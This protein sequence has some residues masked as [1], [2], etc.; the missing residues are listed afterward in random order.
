[1]RSSGSDS[2]R[3]VVWFWFVGIAGLATPNGRAV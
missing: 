2:T 1:M 3:I